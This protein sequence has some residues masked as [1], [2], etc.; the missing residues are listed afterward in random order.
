MKRSRFRVD[1]DGGRASI[2]GPAR[3]ASADVRLR[4]E[5]V[6]GRSNAAWVTLA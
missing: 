3:T 2:R 5:C 1:R 6:R 4:K